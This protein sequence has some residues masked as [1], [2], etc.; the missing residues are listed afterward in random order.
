MKKQIVVL[1]AAVIILFQFS[2]CEKVLA[3][4][5]GGVDV[6]VPDIQIT[7]PVVTGVSPTEVPLGSFSY[8]FN[9]DSIIRAKTAGSFGAN[10]V[11]SVKL[12]Q[13]TINITNADPLNNL[14]NFE[15]VRV[16]IQSNTNSTPVDIF[17]ASF[18]DVYASVYTSTPASSPQLL[19]YIKGSSISYIVYGK[20]RRI[21]TKP[22]TVTFSVIIRTS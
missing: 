7:I 5:F 11:A 22:L 17:S 14:A 21:T 12:N 15:S 1:F 10:D 19:S 18:A 20:N 9:L 2:S 3:A 4:I 16:S 8:A 13:V 6:T